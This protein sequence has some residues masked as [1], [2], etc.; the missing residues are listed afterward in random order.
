MSIGGY[1]SS[2]DADLLKRRWFLLVITQDEAPWLFDQEGQASTRIAAGELLGSMAG[3][4]LFVPADTNVICRATVKCVGA[5]DNKGN[6][7][8]VKKLMTTKLPVAAILMALADIMRDRGVTLDLVWVPRKKNV[9]ADSLTDLDFR[10]FS[11]ELRIPITWSSLRLGYVLSLS[12]VSE[13]FRAQLADL[14]KRRAEASLTD[15]G[16]RRHRRERELE[17]WG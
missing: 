6:S 5:T 11:S 17:P 14:K 15:G 13:D 3:A 16:P 4:L 2:G 7:Y 1:C 10:L 8:I 12:S 9:A